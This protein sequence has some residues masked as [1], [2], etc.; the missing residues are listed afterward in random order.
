MTLLAKSDKGSCLSLLDHTRHVATAI[1]RFA[2]MLGLDVEMARRGAVLH[3]LGKGHP[4]FQAM[5]LGTVRDVQRREDMLASLPAPEAIRREL[6]QRANG[7]SPPHRHEISSLLF[8]PLFDPEEW[9]T[10]IDM[11]AA[12]HKSIKGDAK[13]RG[14]VD[15]VR[16]D[17]ADHVF[18]S[19]LGAWELWSPAVMDVA[20][21]FRIRARPI[22]PEEA[23]TAFDAAVMHCRTKAD[24]WSRW[25][26]LLMSADH[27]ASAYQHSTDGA[28]ASLY[29]APDLSCYDA[30]A[31]S[32]SAVSYPLAAVGAHDP[33]RHTLVTAPTG[34]GKT[35]FL[36]RRCRGRVFYTLPFQASIN[37]M[38]GRIAND[39]GV[40]AGSADVRRLH[41]ASRVELD[42]EAEEDVELQRHPGAGVKVMTP[43]QLASIA[44]GLAGH[45]VMALDV[46]G[47][48]VIL[49]EVHTYSDLAQAM[50]VQ[51]VRRLVGLGC[52]VHIGTATIPTAL[53]NLLEEVL[54]GA[55]AVCRVSL[56]METLRTFNRH[57][58]H[59]HLHQESAGRA[60]SNAIASGQ[61]ILLVSN[62]VDRAQDRFRQ[63]CEDFPNVPAMLIHSR[64]R[65]GDRSR[66]EKEI[67][68]FEEMNG[69]CVVCATQ[70]VEV[71]LDISFDT[72]ITDAAPLDSLI[73]RFGRVNR[74]RNP[75]T[76]GHLKSVHVIA[77]P[78]DATACLPYKADVMHASF[79]CLPDGQPLEESGL[80][81]RI[82]QVYPKVEIPSI[83]QH[84]VL[85]DDGSYR[86]QELQ[87]HPRSVLME[88]LEIESAT[89]VLASDASRYET[90]AWDERL[91]LEIPVPVSVSRFAKGWARIERGSYPLVVPDDLYNP[92]GLPVGLELRRPKKLTSVPTAD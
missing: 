85:A 1:E 41:A 67:K 51:I 84:Q 73:Q 78:E 62:R 26:G 65:R 86:I 34:A 23:R 6:R 36:L 28:A 80:Q 42:Q 88:A 31:R 61:R 7:Q 10:L 15:L 50:V 57:I 53:A 33:R 29:I 16:A 81:A 4:A 64:F 71:S 13:R 54:G 91:E 40:V 11:V 44:F 45:E 92:G 18:A 39:L 82:D 79:A 48:D 47:Q 89:C 24:G 75:G 22:T 87:H 8:L 32:A 83:A 17:G 37:A 76:V 12:H 68:R 19:H 3:D 63:I 9:P 43:H 49:D 27:F 2:E 55:D 70:V 66:L 58:V 90:G 21:K 20:T 38:F 69:P 5:I 77:P 59:R 52:R 30:R 60:V 14:L 35:D 56:D 74:K 46:E 72:M 25:R